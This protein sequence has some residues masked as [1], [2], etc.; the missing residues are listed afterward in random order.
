MLI[1]CLMQVQDYLLSVLCPYV[2]LIN[3]FIEH[4]IIIM[5]FTGFSFF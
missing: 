2:Y 3:Q 1:L 4:L 5:E